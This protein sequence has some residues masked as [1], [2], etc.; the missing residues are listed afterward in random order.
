M[1]TVTE[2]EPTVALAVTVMFASNW[3]ELIIVSEFT[4]M[5]V[6][7][8]MLVTL[9]LMKFVPLKESVMLSRTWP[10]SGVMLANVGTGLFT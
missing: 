10:V 7:T 4:V 8:L 3:A 6:P 1:F 5:P 2:R 9:L